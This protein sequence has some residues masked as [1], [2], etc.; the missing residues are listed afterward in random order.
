MREV[1]VLTGLGS[2]R[3]ATEVMSLGLVIGRWTAVEHKQNA[4][5]DNGKYPKGKD[6]QNTHL[7]ITLTR[8]IVR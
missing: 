8:I 7:K 1:A 2:R 6:P 4:Q 5:Q 3:R